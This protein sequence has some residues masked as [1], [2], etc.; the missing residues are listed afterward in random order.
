[1]KYKHLFGPVTSRRLG[2]SLGVDL[3][4]YKYCPLNCVYCEIQNTTH[5]ETERRAFFPVAE[6]LEELDAFLQKA[7]HLDYITFSGAGEP[8]L[9]SSINTIICHIK[10]KYPSY[11]LALLTNGTLLDNDDVLQDILLCDL[12]LPSLDAA[13]EEVFKIVNRPHPS[14]TAKNL[15]EGLVKLRKAYQGQIW[16]EVFIIQGITDTPE[17]MALLRQAIA[18]IS[19]DL[20]QLNSLD[21]PGA[22]EWVEAAEPERLKE[23]REYMR[24]GLAMPVEIIAKI[25]YQ[26][27][28][29]VLDDEL[30]ELIK[31]T[32]TRRPST[33]EDL[34]A[35]L[36]IH[37]NEI[38]KV[39][40]EL[41]IQG[42]LHTERRARG[43]F[44]TWIA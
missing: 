41:N 22:E 21:R 30:V 38:S 27:G 2:V 24:S 42:K 18:R 39:L 11:K 17:E 14:L 19:P 9:N 40:R 10:E 35:G 13:S 43:V 12:I 44:Y 1:M 15:I 33:A 26:T 28:M 32:I 5:L 34:A 20:V 29:S 8:T 25:K 16:L 3:V 7:P 36:D 23:I 31:G 4:P 37:I 6:I